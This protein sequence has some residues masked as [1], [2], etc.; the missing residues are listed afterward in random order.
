M[1]NVT[2]KAVK[3]LVESNNASGKITCSYIYKNGV[4]NYNIHFSNGA[5][6]TFESSLIQ[7]RVFRTL[8]HELYFEQD[9]NFLTEE[10]EGIIEASKNGENPFAFSIICA[11]TSLNGIYN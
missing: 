2:I 1:K 9:F 8:K 3:K 4:D 10:D 6:L 11:N 7:G 5:V